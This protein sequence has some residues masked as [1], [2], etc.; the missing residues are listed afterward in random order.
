MDILNVAKNYF[1]SAGMVIYPLVFV[2]FCAF[3]S[4]S[5]ILIDEFFAYKNLRNQ[6]VEKVKILDGKFFKKLDRRIKYLG[7]LIFIA[8]LLGLL[9]TVVGMMSVFLG[10][11][12]DSSKI[13]S[14]VSQALITTQLGLSIAVFAMFLK[15]I[16]VSFF[17][18]LRI[19][20]LE[21]MGREFL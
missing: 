4:A 13:I 2:A 18:Y 1:F 20:S 6:D 19:A 14:G 8:P 17:K 5:Q 3:F 15:Y 21:K 11:T 9:G 10:L 16:C 7:A 12:S